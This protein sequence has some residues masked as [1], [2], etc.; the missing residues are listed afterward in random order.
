ML[1]T[2]DN[3]LMKTAKTVGG[4]IGGAIKGATE[5]N[6]NIIVCSH[7]DVKLTNNENF[8]YLQ[9]PYCN[10]Y[11]LDFNQINEYDWIEIVF[12]LTAKIAKIDGIVTKDEAQ[13]IGNYIKEL[14]LNERESLF[15]KKIFK[16][17]K[18]DD[19]YDINYY[20]NLLVTIFNYEKDREV[21]FHWLCNLSMADNFL[22]E[23]ENKA[24]K[25]L[26]KSLK[27]NEQLYDAFLLSLDKNHYCSISDYYKILGCFENCSD[28]EL[29]KIYREKIKEFHPDTIASKNLPESF[30]RFATE[31]MQII[32]NAYEQIMIS[33][34][35]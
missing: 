20:A 34:R 3:I 22:D 17:V 19:T 32:N 9:C 24:L 8:K 1:K 14:E 25:N 28:N 27:I 4:M 15:A 13:M 29:K 31:Q 2:I 16:E 30:I 26:T 5:A 18:D 7:C 33:R 35:K 23:K 21:I 10:K 11:F 6:Q 12:S